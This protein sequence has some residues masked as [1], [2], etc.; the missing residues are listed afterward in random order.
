ME[1][2]LLAFTDRGQPISVRTTKRVH[3]DSET[4]V[5]VAN[6]DDVPVSVDYSDGFGRLIQTR[7]QAEDTL[8]GD[9][10]FGGGVISVDQSVAVS[11]AVGQ[12]RAATDP[13][14]VVVSGW[15]VYDNKG[16]VVEKFEPFFDKD[17]AFSAPDA[18]QLGQ[19]VTIFYDPRGQ[20]IRT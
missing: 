8:F 20:A 15:Q 16:H 7:I 13:D 14:N 2:D 17:Y 10:A 9:P 12:T 3:H 4:D 11:A 6:R 18:N 19:K 1:Y 5:P